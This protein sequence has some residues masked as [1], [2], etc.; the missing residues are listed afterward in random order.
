MSIANS[1]VPVQNAQSNQPQSIQQPQ[2][3]SFQ[4]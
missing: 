1:Q 4:P 2:Q 3:I